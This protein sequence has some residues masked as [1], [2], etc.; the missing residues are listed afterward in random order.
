MKR[1]HGLAQQM[2]SILCCQ[3]IQMG[4]TQGA[5]AG[6]TIVQLSSRRYPPERAL[7]VPGTPLR[8]TCASGGAPGT[9]ELQPESVIMFM[10]NISP[11]ALGSAVLLDLAAMNPRYTESY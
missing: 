11:R 1:G 3:E 8:A 5:V 4:L 6:S 9:R 7:K 10:P 2:H